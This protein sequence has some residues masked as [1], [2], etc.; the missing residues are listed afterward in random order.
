MLKHEDLKKVKEAV[1][2]I[3]EENS[4]KP[5]NRVCALWSFH[6]AEMLNMLTGSD[7]FRPVF[8]SMTI[9]VNQTNKADPSEGWYWGYDTF[10]PDSRPDEFH[11]WIVSRGGD[12]IDF[13][14]EFMKENFEAAKP[15]LEGAGY[16]WNR[17][18]L[19]AFLWRKNFS[20]SEINAN[21][22][23]DYREN[24]KLTE[25]ILAGHTNILTLLED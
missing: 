19:P 10:L 25:V 2:V 6:G 11:G 15:F 9:C 4:D 13:T 17:S 22:G 24:E 23:I 21:K 3:I 8:G 16:K 12:L 20:Y 1:R 7:D 5:I 14:T 18:P